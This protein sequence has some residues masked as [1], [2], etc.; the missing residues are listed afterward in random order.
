MNTN[1]YE[2]LNPVNPSIDVPDLYD[3]NYGN[4]ASNCEINGGSCHDYGCGC[5]AGCRCNTLDCGY[6]MGNR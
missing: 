4:C 6:R 5:D 2:I 3:N 1:G